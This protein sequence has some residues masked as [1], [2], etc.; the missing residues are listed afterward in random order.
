MTWQQKTFAQLSSIELFDIFALR[1]QIFIVEQHCPY[2][3]I[4]HYDQQALH[5]YRYDK[6]QLIAYARLLPAGTKYPQWVIGRVVVA[7]PYRHQKLGNQLMQTAIDSIV[8]RG[9]KQIRISAQ[10]HL[11]HF[12]QQLRFQTVSPPYDEDGIPHIDMRYDRP[13]T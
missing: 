5:L 1:Q 9:G 4:D 6:E 10:A 11:E 8:Q 12:Y 7:K 2:I 3:D 13:E